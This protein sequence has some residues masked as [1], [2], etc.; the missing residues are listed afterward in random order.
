MT[1]ANEGLTHQ[2][3]TLCLSITISGV[4]FYFG[5]LILGTGRLNRILDDV[6]LMSL[7]D[8][9]C[10]IGTETSTFAFENHVLEY[11]DWCELP[12]WTSLVNKSRFTGSSRCRFR[13]QFLANTT[14][15]C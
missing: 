10:A 15:C 8:V 11:E 14:F 4:R 6:V 1:L 7:V 9:G 3:P 13:L 5:V 12:T 2:F